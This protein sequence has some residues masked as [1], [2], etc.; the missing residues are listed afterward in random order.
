MI[1]GYV[2]FGI[3]LMGGL[4]AAETLY[5][6]HSGRLFWRGFVPQ[7]L[8]LSLMPQDEVRVDAWMV[9]EE[10]VILLLTGAFLTL[11]LIAL[12]FIGFLKV[13]S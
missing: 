4:I 2:L 3:F 5:Y 10:T 8:R 6:R 9:M 11:P 7:A 1:I 13:F 12:D